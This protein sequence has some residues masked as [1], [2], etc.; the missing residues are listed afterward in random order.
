MASCIEV[1]TAVSST[2]RLS[3]FKVHPNGQALMTESDTKPNFHRFS[4]SWD[5]ADKLSRPI[6]ADATSTLHSTICLFQF[7]VRP[8]GQALTT[9]SNTKPNF[10]R[11]S[12]SWDLA[13]M[14]VDLHI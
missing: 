1:T 7:K 3:Q 8:N 6:L 4:V 12:V 2:R 14:A 9:E 10:H 13:V 11:F 5:L